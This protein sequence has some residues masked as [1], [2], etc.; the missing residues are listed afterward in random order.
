MVDGDGQA[1]IDYLD[2]L[3]KE[4]Y[5]AFKRHGAE[6]DQFHKGYALAIDSLLES[7]ATCDKRKQKQRNDASDAYT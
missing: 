5:E 6:H 7:F 1:L 4:N 3:S 2:T